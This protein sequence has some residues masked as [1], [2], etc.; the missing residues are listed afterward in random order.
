MAVEDQVRAVVP[1]LGHLIQALRT[2]VVSQVLL[3]GAPTLV[4]GWLLL[5]T[6]RPAPTP[7]DEED[8]A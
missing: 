4:V 3:Y 7:N 1:E 8:Q 2:P 5:S 6:W